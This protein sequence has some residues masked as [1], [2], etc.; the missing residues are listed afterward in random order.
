MGSPAVLVLLRSWGQPE[1]ALARSHL[2]TILVWVLRRLVP[3]NLLQS[4]GSSCWVRMRRGFSE[5]FFKLLILL[6]R[7]NNL[8]AC[9][10]VYFINFRPLPHLFHYLVISRFQELL[11]LV[12][13]PSSFPFFHA[14]LLPRPL[15]EGVGFFP[16]RLG[17]RL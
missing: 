17:C 7:T 9:Y 6:R 15:H 12:C 14:L 11:Q 4:T 13:I 10:R 8:A 5:T 3:L 1:S 2:K 16:F